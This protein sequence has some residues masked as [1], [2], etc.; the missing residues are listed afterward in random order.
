MKKFSSESWNR[1]PGEVVNATPLET[2]K[3][4]LGG[5]SSNLI[6]RDV[7]CV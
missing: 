5:T 2:F 3:A 4:E 6:K 1:F 7:S